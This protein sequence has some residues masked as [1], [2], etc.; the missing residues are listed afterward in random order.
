MSKF[1]IL[2]MAVVL[3][4]GCASQATKPFPSTE[5]DLFPERIQLTVPG[6]PM[7]VWRESVPTQKDLAHFVTESVPVGQT[8]D[9]WEDLVLIDYWSHYQNSKTMDVFAGQLQQTLQ[10]TCPNVDFK[11]LGAGESDLMYEWSVR[12][13]A[14][15]DDQ[16]EVG[17]YILT[18]NG[19]HRVL[20]AHKG[21]SLSAAQWAQWR[22]A[23]RTAQVRDIRPPDGS[24]VA[25]GRPYRPHWKRLLNEA[26]KPVLSP[27]W[28]MNTDASQ[29][30]KK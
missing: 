28:I 16:W 27:R 25:I 29:G 6:N 12:E 17:R 20:Y 4:A 26:P 24:P 5:L 1:G 23:M 14:V 10:S 18:E 11:R 8:L 13:C 19:I 15:M 22:Q 2:P 3:F 21:P 30:G 7:R 9:G